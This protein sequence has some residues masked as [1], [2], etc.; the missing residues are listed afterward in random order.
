M[1]VRRV[2]PDGA[3]ADFILPAK[4]KVGH[5]QREPVSLVEAV[6]KT[7]LDLLNPALKSFSPE[8]VEQDHGTRHDQLRTRPRRGQ[9]TL[10]C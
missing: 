5:S 7:R 3:K 2:M 1:F 10:Q 9:A 6:K 8:V 4:I